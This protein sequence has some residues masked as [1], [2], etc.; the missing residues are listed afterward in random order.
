MVGMGQVVPDN[1]VGLEQDHKMALAVQQFDQLENEAAKVTPKVETDGF[2]PQDRMKVHVDTPVSLSVLDVSLVGPY[3]EAVKV[4]LEDCKTA[5]AGCKII[6]TRPKVV[7]IR[8]SL[9]VR[10]HTLARPKVVPRRVVLVGQKHILVETKVAPERFP[11][12]IRGLPRLG[13]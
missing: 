10:M 3:G 1:Q 11:L 13:R 5:L 7:P 9:V 6:P 2:A 8:V 4:D 12:L